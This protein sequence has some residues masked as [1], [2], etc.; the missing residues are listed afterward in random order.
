MGDTPGTCPR[1]GSHDIDT[2]VYGEP[3]H[4]LKPGT[5]AGGCLV[6][7]D[8]PDCVCRN[9]EHQW[10]IPGSFRARAGAEQADWH[11]H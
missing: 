5:I 9:C 1:C 2:V 11:H 3:I 7:P 8:G 6:T 4:P 10:Q